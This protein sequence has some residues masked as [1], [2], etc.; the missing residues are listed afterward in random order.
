MPHI[1]FTIIAAVVFLAFLGFAI[2]FLVLKKRIRKGQ[3]IALMIVNW[4]FVVGA[5]FFL[6][7]F[8]FGVFVF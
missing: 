3:D 2:T 5:L 1:V 4:V 8:I 6:F 7:L